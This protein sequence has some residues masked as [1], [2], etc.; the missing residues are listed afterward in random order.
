MKRYEYK[1][2]SFNRNSLRDE[3]SS[4]AHRLNEEGA[5]GWHVITVRDDPREGSGLIF[6]LEREVP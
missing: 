5:H 4:E 3:E 6:I 1:V 2:V